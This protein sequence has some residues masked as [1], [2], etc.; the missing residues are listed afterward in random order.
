MNKI[1][2]TYKDWVKCN[3]Q[4]LTDFDKQMLVNAYKIFVPMARF[5]PKYKLGVW[6]GYI[7]FFELTGNTYVSLVPEILSRLDLSHYEDVEYIYAKDLK[8]DVDLGDD[9]DNDYMSDICWDEGHRLA[10]QPIRLEDHQVRV[11]NAFLHNHRGVVS[12]CTGSGKTLISAALFRK[13]KTFGRSVIVVPSKDLAQQSAEDY[14]KWGLDCGIV[15][16]GLREFGHN[17]TVCTWQTINSLEKRKNKEDSLTADEL[18]Q[19]TADVVCIIFDECHCCK[20]NEIKKVLENTFRNVP[21]RYGLTGT[22]NKDK[23]EY[24]CLRTAIG[25]VLDEKVTAKELQDLGFL[26]NCNINCIRLDDNTLCQTYADEVDYL[27]SNGDRLS[28]IAKMIAQIASTNNNTLVL[29]GR[30]SMGEYL[31]KELTNLGADAIFL[32]G[33]VK[34]KKRFAEYESI[35]TQNNR[36]LICTDKIASTGLNIPRLFNIV[37]IDFGKSFTKT[38]QSI[39][40]GLRKASDK[41]KVTIFDISSTTKYSKKHFNDR[42]HFY[43]E[44]QYPYS[45][46]NVNNNAWK[47]NGE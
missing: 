10:G 28:F 22:V 1:I 44:A 26:S 19:L 2:I 42:I 17:V 23:S 35:K 14:K 34:S 21:I 15:G 40:R 31:E 8:Q 24:M 27:C 7:R 36:C 47:K 4:G 43:E 25:N 11:V 12:S 20:G 5:S 32:N 16:C 38:L 9:I 3:I 41:D 13:I 45:I 37:F 30:I 18:K 29:V 39:G 33:S 6:D 46:Y